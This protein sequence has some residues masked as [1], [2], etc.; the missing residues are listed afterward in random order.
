MVA[1]SG[2]TSKGR[3]TTEF[4]ALR[5]KLAGTPGFRRTMS[6]IRSGATLS[7]ANTSTWVIETV[8]NA[9]ETAIFVER[10]SSEGSF[11]QALP[12]KVAESIYRQN[13]Q[14]KTKGRKAA[15]KAEAMRRKAL[16]VVPFVKKTGE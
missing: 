8:R 4:D 11:R 10:I 15:A 13:E 16:G 9:E 3:P 12:H 5:D 7:D 1:Q 14:L 2:D 6:T